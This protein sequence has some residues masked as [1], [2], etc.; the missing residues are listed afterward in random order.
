MYKGTM[1]KVI[2]TGNLGAD[3]EIKAIGDTH[4]VNARLATSRKTRDGE[5]TDWHNIKVWGKQAEAF[6]SLM[7]KGSK[8][9]VEGEVQYQQWETDAGEKRI[10]PIIFCQRWQGLTGF[11][12]NPKPQDSGGNNDFGGPTPEDFDNDIPFN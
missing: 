10:T 12:D 5:A 3:P 7:Q 8:L 1:N 2:L 4:V 11:R 9:T 6:A